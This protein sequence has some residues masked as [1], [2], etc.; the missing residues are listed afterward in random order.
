MKD[1]F[2]NLKKEL[3]EDATPFGGTKPNILMLAAGLFMTIMF[4]IACC[5][6]VVG[7]VVGIFFAF[8]SSPLLGV[9][10]FGLLVSFI[11]CVKWL[12]S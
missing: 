12:A 10:L 4:G 5:V 8:T 6:A 9:G 7:A 2:L 11:G 3:V 1:F